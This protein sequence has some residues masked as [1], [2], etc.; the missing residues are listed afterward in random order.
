MNEIYTLVNVKY[1]MDYE[2]EEYTKQTG[3]CDGYDFFG[4]GDNY[5]TN[6]YRYDYYGLERDENILEFESDFIRNKQSADNL[7]DF[8]YMYHCN[9]HAIAKATLPLKYSHLELGDIIQFDK[10]VNSIKSLGEDYTIENTRN[11]QTIYPY[12][13]VTSVTKSPKNIKIEATQ[14][15]RLVRSFTPAVGSLSRMSS[16]EE[17]NINNLTLYDYNILYDIILNEEDPVNKYI[18]SEQKRVSD[19]TSNGNISLNDL[20]ML[21]QFLGI[22]AIVD[23]E[24]YTS[25]EDE[26]DEDLTSLLGDINNDGTVNVVDVVMLVNFILGETTGTSEQVDVADYNEDGTVNVVDI[27]NIVHEILGLS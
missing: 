20:N 5:Y 15:H 17:D 26:T 6:G 23:S 8:L 21:G 11:G 10:I 9:H 7:R 22:E 25:N 18:T 27:V 24:E 16:S 14:L 1:K 13:M 3:Y 4:N 12:F 19:L 2:E